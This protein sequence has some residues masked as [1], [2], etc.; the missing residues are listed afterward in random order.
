[1]QSTPTPSVLNISM[2]VRFIV[3]FEVNGRSEIL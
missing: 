2:A 3:D 1:M